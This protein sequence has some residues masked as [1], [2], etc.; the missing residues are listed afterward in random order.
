MSVPADHDGLLPGRDQPRNVVAN[1]GLAEYG[2]TEDVPDGAVG[3]PP[4][5]LQLELLY[6]GLVRRDGRALDADV[7]LLDGFGAFD[8]DLVVGLVPAL[9]AKVVLVKLHVQVGLEELGL[10]VVPDDPGHL[11]AEDVHHGSGLDLVVGHLGLKV[12]FHEKN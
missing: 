12:K 6:P 5:L 1:D 2:A 9:D 8:R 11:V 3:R 7:V 10:D 4:H